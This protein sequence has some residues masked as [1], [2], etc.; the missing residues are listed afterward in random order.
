MIKNLTYK[1][2]LAGLSVLA[3]LSVFLVY[4]IALSETV[5]VKRNLDDV[6]GKLAGLEALPQKIKSAENELALL[7]RKIGEDIQG[8]QE[9]QKT[10]FDQ[11]SG[12]CSKYSLVLRDFPRI[13][14]FQDMGFTYL[15]GYAR[16][17]GPYIALLKMLYSL[18][19]GPSPGRILS[20]D[21][22]SAEDR[23]MNRLRLTMAVYFQTT[24]QDNYAYPE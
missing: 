7:N 22:I 13:E 12:N 24:K 2:R 19:T 14:T 20:V 5:R 4:F 15:T 9:F 17:E 1:Q 6:E 8:N 3:L 23:R 21:F 16:V 11:V 10:L 18:E